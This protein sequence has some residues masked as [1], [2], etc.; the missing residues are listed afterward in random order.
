VDLVR[1]PDGGFGL[2]GRGDWRLD[3]EATADGWVVRAA[4]GGGDW[5]LRRA[6]GESGGFVLESEEGERRLELGRT[7]H[8]PGT[9][10]VE[11]PASVL[12]ADGRLFRIL[13]RMGREPRLEVAGW[14][15]SGAYW[16]ARPLEGQWRLEPTPAGQVLGDELELLVLVAAE[17]LH[18]E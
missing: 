2:V 6:S 4:R 12:L 18:T 14:E 3:A 9:H 15:V 8:Y 10:D 17:I 1:N 16:I 11:G 7:S 5:N 13:P